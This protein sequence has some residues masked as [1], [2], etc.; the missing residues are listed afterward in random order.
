MWGLVRVTLGWVGRATKRGQVRPRADDGDARRGYPVPLEDDPPVRVVGG[1]DV[2]SCPCRASLHEP[3]RSIHEPVPVREARLE[4]LRAEIVVIENEGRPVEDAKED[5]DGPEEVRRIAA[6]HDVESTAEARPEA[7]P[8]R[9]DERVHVF[10]D[11]GDAR[12]TRCERS[13][14]EEIDSAQPVVGRIAGGL[15]ADHR[16]PEPG[17]DQ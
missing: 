16:D 17:G 9:H 2:V 4:E 10:E 6:L 3:Q 14:L 12:R 11:E 5:S 13:V 8:Q 7:E 1:D 15:G